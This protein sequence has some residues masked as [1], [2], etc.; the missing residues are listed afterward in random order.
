MKDLIVKFENQTAIPKFVKIISP[1]TGD[2]ELI[3]ENFILDA[4]S[5]MGI[6]SL[7]LSNPITLRVYEYNDEI[8]VLLKDY[9]IDEGI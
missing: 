1:L 7:G 4:R 6:Y 5:L 3:Q 8:L 9:I 2:F